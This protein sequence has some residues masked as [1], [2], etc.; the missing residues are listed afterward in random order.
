MRKSIPLY[1]F[2]QKNRQTVKAV[3][4]VSKHQKHVEIPLIENK[5]NINNNK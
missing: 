5:Y 4:G 1:Y 2:K 3:I